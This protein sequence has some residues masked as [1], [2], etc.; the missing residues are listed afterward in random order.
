MCSSVASACLHGT[1][2]TSYIMSL[3]VMSLTTGSHCSIPSIYLIFTEELDDSHEDSDES[4]VVITLL[5]SLY[6][7]MYSNSPHLF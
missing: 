1:Q 2:R 6:E 5:D 4:T 3:N 7:N